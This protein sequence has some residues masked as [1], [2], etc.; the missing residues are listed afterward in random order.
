MFSIFSD[1]TIA[2]SRAVSAVITV[3]EAWKGLNATGD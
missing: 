3:I 1:L 2:L